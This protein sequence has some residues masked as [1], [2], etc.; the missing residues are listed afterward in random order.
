MIFGVS[1]VYFLFI[2]M[3]LIVSILG[4]VLWIWMIIDAAKNEKNDDLLVWI[5]ILVFLQFIG[6]VVYY[7]V[8]K[9]P[10][11]QKKKNGGVSVS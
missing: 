1:V 7:F 9:R 10:R 2:G 5:L 4:T 8:R 11:D 6:A 3:I